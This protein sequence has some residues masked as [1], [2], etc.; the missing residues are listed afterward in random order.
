MMVRYSD[1][2]FLEDSYVNLRV[3]SPTFSSSSSDTVTITAPAPATRK[4]SVIKVYGSPWQ[5]EFYGWAFNAQRGPEILAKWRL[6]PADVDILLT[7]GPP[8]GYGDTTSGGDR[9]GCLD[10]MNELTHRIRPRLHVFGHIHEGAGV[11]THNYDPSTTT[12]IPHRS[13]TM[14]INACTCDL[15][16]RPTHPPISLKYPLSTSDLPSLLDQSSYHVTK[17]GGN[18]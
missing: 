8:F 4:P 3:L 14:L 10:L 18:T 6:I 17:D 15:N 12:D 7:H 11:W 16:Y 1:I 2:I 5:P 13:S 9:V